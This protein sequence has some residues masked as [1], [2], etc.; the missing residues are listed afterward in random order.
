MNTSPKPPSAPSRKRRAFLTVGGLAAAGV[1][2]GAGYVA[3]HRDHALASAEFRDLP[4]ALR[5]LDSLRTTPMKMR[6]GWDLPHVLHHAAQSIHGSIDGY[7]HPKPAW[8][9]ASIGSAA[10]SVFGARGRMNHGLQ[11]PIPG[12]PTIPDGLELQPAIHDVMQALQRF[13]QHTGPL[14]PHFAYGALDKSDYA[15]AHL[16]HIA[17]HWDLIVPA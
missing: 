10:F 15:R 5:T 1:A 16:M 11:D 14:A 7:P 3:T 8:F 4:T 13:D 9:Q 17:N 12:L 2:A 6:S